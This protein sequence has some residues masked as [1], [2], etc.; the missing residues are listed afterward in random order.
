[1]IPARMSLDGIVQY[2]SL[3]LKL[4]SE[5]EAHIRDCHGHENRVRWDDR[6]YRKIQEG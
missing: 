3:E 1:M 6:N 5:K 4:F 2:V